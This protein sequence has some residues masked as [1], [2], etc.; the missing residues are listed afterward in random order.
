MAILEQSVVSYPD[1]GP[2]GQST[3]R[4]NT[5]GYLVRDLIETYGATAVLD[6][7]AGSGTTKDVVAHLNKEGHE[8]ASTFLDFKD[9]HDIL[10]P[11]TH[12]RIERDARDFDQ[13]DF[14]FL[15]PPYWNMIKYSD[16]RHDFSNGSYTTYLARMQ[17]TI[18]FLHTVARPGGVLAIQLGD[19]RRGGRTYFMTDD[20]TYND[21]RIRP[22]RKEF[23]FIKLQHKTVTGGVTDYPVRLSH[24]CVTILRK[25]GAL[26]S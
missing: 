19:L 23:R 11:R 7:M 22:W 10:D 17:R 14:I 16:D 24:E 26:P 6:P 13:F 3:F 9:G 15:H 18:K 5:S 2:Y 21:M 1:R 8:I 25:G 4:G 12:R 20:V